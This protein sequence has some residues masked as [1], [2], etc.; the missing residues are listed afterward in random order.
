MPRR[1]GRRRQSIGDGDGGADGRA[2]IPKGGITGYKDVGSSENS[3]MSAVAQQPVSIAVQAKIALDRKLVDAGAV[4][5][6]V[7]QGID[8]LRMGLSDMRAMY[9]EVQSGR[10]PPVVPFYMPVPT[11]FDPD[12]AP[13]GCQLLTVCALAPTTD[14]PLE[15]PGARWEEAKLNAVRQVVP[16]L[17]DHVLFIDRF[18][19]KFIAHWIGKEHGPAISTGQTPGQVGRDRP[20]VWTPLRG[21]YV[22]GCGAGARGVGTELAAASAMACVDQICADRGLPV[23]ARQRARRRVRYPSAA[24]RAAVRPMAWMLG[25]G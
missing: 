3:L 6:G 5:G 21:L 17:D 13:P 12:L 24:V 8:L 19:T 23:A 10:I 25:P 2:G 4:V 14:V 7:G 22:A 16:G 15:D 18:S 20:P 9:D 11:N 1:I